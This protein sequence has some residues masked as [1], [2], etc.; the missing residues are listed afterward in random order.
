MLIYIDG[1]R[2][3]GDAPGL[4]PEPLVSLRT[5]ILTILDPSELQF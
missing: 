3:T 5:P 2:K 1:L 4:S